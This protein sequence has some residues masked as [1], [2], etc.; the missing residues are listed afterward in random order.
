MEVEI[1]IYKCKK[2]MN[3]EKTTINLAI[4]PAAS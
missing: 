2:I 4:W 1:M 3:G